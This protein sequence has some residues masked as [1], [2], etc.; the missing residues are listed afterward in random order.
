MAEGLELAAYPRRLDDLSDGGDAVRVSETFESVWHPTALSATAA[1]AVASPPYSF[2]VVGARILTDQS[3]G[4]NVATSDTNYWLVQVRVVG[5]GTTSA[6]A[7]KTTQATG[8]EQITHRTLWTF[9]GVS[10][11]PSAAID[12]SIYGIDFAFTRNGTPSNVPPLI[13]QVRYEAV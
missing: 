10:G 12:G 3:G 9:D 11:L 1:I 5:A 4:G 8:G 7:G 13:C 6:L 2:K